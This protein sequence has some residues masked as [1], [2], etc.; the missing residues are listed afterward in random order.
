MDSMLRRI[1]GASTGLSRTMERLHSHSRLAS[2]PV[3]ICSELSSSVSFVPE[4]Q[5]EACQLS[6]LPFTPA[7]HSAGSYPGAQFYVRQS[8]YFSPL[9]VLSHFRIFQLECAQLAIT[10]GGSKSPATVSFP[11][12]YKGTSS[13]S[14]WALLHL[15]AKGSDPGITIS[16]Y[17]PPVTNYTVPG[18]SQLMENT[19][20][21]MLS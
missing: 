8:Y 13:S 6:K 10:G 7:L 19:G 20:T 11:G 9:S 5:S 12:A 16:I 3:N 18:K 15:I 21:L 17:W 4:L 1:P 14:T 2:P